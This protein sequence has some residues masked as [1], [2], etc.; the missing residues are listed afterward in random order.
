MV[1]KHGSAGPSTAKVLEVQGTNLGV[2]YIP[3]LSSWSSYPL[4]T[5]HVL[6]R[7]VLLGLLK[8]I[9]GPERDTQW[10]AHEVKS[11]VAC[12]AQGVH[13]VEIANG[14]HDVTRYVALWAISELFAW[15]DCFSK[16]V[17]F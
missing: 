5:M 16:P 6:L 13:R 4:P 7:G 2:Q 17:L 1:V 8:S 10:I 3:Y 15:A 11:L 9:L 12:R 14:Y